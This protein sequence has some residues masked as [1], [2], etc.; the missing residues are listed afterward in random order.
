MDK[1]RQYCS[2]REGY[3]DG[4]QQDEALGAVIVG[5]LPHPSYF[6]EMPAERPRNDNVVG[7]EMVED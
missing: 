3:C 6:I 7:M 5:Y 4:R 2:G 1:D